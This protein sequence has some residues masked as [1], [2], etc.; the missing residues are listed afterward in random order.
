MRAMRSGLVLLLLSGLAAADPYV[1]Q[2]G[3]ALGR[4]CQ[5]RYGSEHYAGLLALHNRL[6]FAAL[7]A[8]Q[9]LDL[10]TLEALVGQD[11]LGEPATLIVQARARFMSVEPGLWGAVKA[12]G[13]P[14]EAVRQPLLDAEAAMRRAAALM[15]EAGLS[16]TQPL[17]TAVLLHG[18]AESGPD[19]NGYNLSDIHRRMSMSL[20]VLLRDHVRR[21]AP[22]N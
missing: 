15:K 3:D 17:G 21:A 6:E 20:E 18:V 1:V 13:R 19:A 8:G 2:K 5:A 11:H 12:P 14:A 22:A 4:L 9:S 16:N 7:R 10:P